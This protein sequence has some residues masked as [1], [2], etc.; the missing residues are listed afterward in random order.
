MRQNLES[1]VKILFLQSHLVSTLNIKTEIENVETSLITHLNNVT[2]EGLAVIKRAVKD[3]SDSKKEKKDDNSSSVRIDKLAKP[4]IELLETNVIILE[5]AMNVF[6]PSC[7]HFNLSKP[8]KELFLSFLNEIIVYFDKIS[9]KITSLFEKQRYHAFDEI[10]GFVNIMDALRKIKAVKQRTQRSYSQIIER[11]FGFV[12][13]QTEAVDSVVKNR[14]EQLEKEAMTNL[15]VK[16]LIP[17]LLAMKEISM[18][19]FSFKNVVDKRIDELLGAYK[20]HNKGGMSI[21]LLALQLEKEPSGIGKIIV[22]EHNAF[23]G[24]NVSLFNVK[25][26]SHGIDYIL[27][28]IETKGDKVDASKLKKIYEEFNSLY[29]KLVKENLTE[30]KQNV[31]T[32]VNN[33]KMITRAI[34]N[35]IPDL[36]AHIFAL[37]TLQ[38]AQFYFD[39]KGIEGQESYLLQPHAAQ[40]ISIFRMLR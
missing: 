8:T 13:Q 23:K 31:I 3:E 6:K 21:S 32:L 16:H 18:Y 27:K 33:T 26:Q 40:V 11:I 14:T 22:A 4:D 10:K 29:R 15:V 36:M 1:L 5:T 19:I 35:K 25:T 38:N 2:N 17:Q 28:K 30:D 24:Y 37:W 20:R 39:A 7:E 9:Q 12:K 34:R